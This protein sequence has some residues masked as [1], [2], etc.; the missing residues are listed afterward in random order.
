MDSSDSS[1]AD[2]PRS[3]TVLTAEAA[4][5]SMRAVV[6][7]DWLACFAARDRAAL[8]DAFFER[9]P[10]AALLQTLVACGPGP[11]PNLP[12]SLPPG[13]PLHN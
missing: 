5:V 6:A 12:A 13:A 3:T 9:A 2:L 7:P 1:Q 4:N 10:C 8:F 11:C